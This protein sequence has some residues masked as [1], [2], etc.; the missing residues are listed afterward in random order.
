MKWTLESN[1]LCYAFNRNMDDET[2]RIFQKA[3]N[4]VQGDRQFIHKLL[5]KYGLLHS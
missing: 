1:P 5:Q 3:L 4:D 2:I